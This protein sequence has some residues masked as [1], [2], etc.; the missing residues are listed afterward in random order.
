MSSE[1]QYQGY[2]ARDSTGS[3]YENSRSPNADDGPG[4]P[5]G[6]EFDEDSQDSLSDFSSIHLDGYDG[7]DS[8]QT[9]FGQ[10]HNTIGSEGALANASNGGSS[11]RKRAFSNAGSSTGSGEKRTATKICRVCGDKAFLPEER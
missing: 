1:V 5:N 2:Y 7:G 11:N 3:D 8:Q 10:R 4:S 6:Y 9:S